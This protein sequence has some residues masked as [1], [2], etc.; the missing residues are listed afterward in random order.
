MTDELA[1][2]LATGPHCLLSALV[3][4]WAGATR[5][6][7]TPGE[8]ADESEATG[9]VRVI[10][11]G[12]FVVHEYRGSLVGEVMEGHAPVGFHIARNRFICAWVDSVHN[13]TSVMLSEGEPGVTDAI[14]V[15]GSYDV[16]GG[17]PWSWR[18][19]MSQPLADEL[20]ISHFNIPPGGDEYL[21]VETQY[22][23]VV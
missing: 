20:V 5:T 3:G 6:W 8:F 14:S 16:A 17:P 4:S 18:T 22:Q 15:L 10:L 21:G 11:G 2:S 7:F 23:R 1:T 12:R 9:T 13:G 19:T